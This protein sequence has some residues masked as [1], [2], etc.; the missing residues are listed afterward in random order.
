MEIS[1]KGPAH[2]KGSRPPAPG[3]KS[4]VFRDGRAAVIVRDEQVQHLGRPHVAQELF[5]ALEPMPMKR[6]HVVQ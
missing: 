3:P 2:L 6:C 5:G 1:V 4:R